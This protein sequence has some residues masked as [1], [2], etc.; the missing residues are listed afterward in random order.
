MHIPKTGGLWVSDILKRHLNV[1]AEYSAHIMPFGDQS[2]PIIAVIRDPVSWWESWITWGRF[3]K[4]KDSYYEGLLRDGDQ[5][6]ADEIVTMYKANMRRLARE[7]SNQQVADMARQRIG[8]LTHRIGQLI[9]HNTYFV[10]FDD[11]R[12]DWC[13]TLNR[14][15]LLTP[16]LENDLLTIPAYNETEKR[17]TITVDISDM[18]HCHGII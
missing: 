17:S 9:K 15:N 6:P 2:L 11:L 4:I 3:H 14:L 10:R 18:E 16:E 1:T 5:R 12:Q 13:R 7:S 8:P